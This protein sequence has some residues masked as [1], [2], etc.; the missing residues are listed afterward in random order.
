MANPAPVT[1]LVSY[2]PKPGKEKALLALVRKH[3]PTLR[4]VKLV[5]KMAP[6]I[7]RARDVREKTSY[8]VEMFQWK[9]EKSSGIAHQ[10]P[11]VMAIWESM[12]PILQK[13]QL[14]QIEPAR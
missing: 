12:G 13:L 8:F 3:W 14:T 7:W 6:K 1:M 11:E 10:T 9:D 5:S 4:R 2:F